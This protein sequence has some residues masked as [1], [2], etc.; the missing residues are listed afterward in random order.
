MTAITNSCEQSLSPRS[1]EMETA[2][3]II[4]ARDEGEFVGAIVQATKKHLQHVIVID[5]HSTDDTSIRADKAGALVLTTSA[6]SGY[7]GA[8]LAGCKYAL[9]HGF[10]TILM[11]D[12]DG[13]HDPEDIPAMVHVHRERSAD[14]TLGDRFQPG[15]LADIPSPKRW[16]NYFATN[17]VNTILGTSVP[18]VACGFRVLSERQAMALLQQAPMVGFTLMFQCIAIARRQRFQIESVPI[19]VRYDATELARTLRGELV[20]L[21][22]ICKAA[23]ETREALHVAISRLLKMAQVLDIVS[24]V[25]G[26]EVLCLIPVGDGY[27][28]QRQPRWFSNR[29][30][31]VIIDL[32]DATKKDVSTQP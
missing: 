8:L 10:E 9:E 11:L 25:V 7:S 30:V 22:T 4:P 1:S 15:H 13:A 6:S 14:L 21:L 5:D 17:L 18:D 29:A 23:T 20:D 27:V 26:G 3:A 28:F 24:I 12:A 2:I 16:A 19:R 32:D 31:G